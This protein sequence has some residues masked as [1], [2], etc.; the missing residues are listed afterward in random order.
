M[1]TEEPPA[2][3]VQTPLPAGVSQPQATAVRLVPVA[4]V[5]VLNPRHRNRKIFQEIVDNIAA[6]GLK[7]PITVTEGQHDANGTRYDL[8]CGQGRLEACQALGETMVPAIVIEASE[9]DCYLMSLVENLA[10]RVRTPMDL[11]NAI[12]SLKERGYSVD[13]IAEKTN[14]GRTYVH[15]VIALMRDGEERLVTAVEKGQIPLAVA[16]EIARADDAQVQVLLA[17]AYESG[18]LRGDRLVTAR[19]VAAERRQHGK[20]FGKPSYVRSQPN[21]AQS[22]IKAYETEVRRQKL[23]ISRAELTEQRLLFVVTA[24]KTLLRDEHFLT[25]LRAEKLETLPKYL[26]EQIKERVP[27]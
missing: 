26:A 1:T 8:V 11:I 19:R 13:E 23:M 17:D 25:L 15:G 24:L 3:D 16:M 14:L 4:A 2:E 22:L 5:R 18:A 20:R 6:L 9:A 10:R 7:R 27:R 12:M 21:T